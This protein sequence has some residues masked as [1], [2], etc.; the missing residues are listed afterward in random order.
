M[1]TDLATDSGEERN[2]VASWSY[3]QRSTHVSGTRRHERLDDWSTRLQARSSCLRAGAVCD[4][5]SDEDQPRLHEPNAS[6]KEPPNGR[7]QLRRGAPS[8]ACRGWAA[9]LSASHEEKSEIHCRCA[10]VSGTSSPRDRRI[11]LIAVSGF[12]PPEMRAAAATIADRPMPWRQWTAT[13]LPACSATTIWS[14]S[15][16]TASREFGTLRS[17]IGKERNSSPLAAEEA[18]SPARASSASSSGSKSDTT[19]SMPASRQARVSSSSHSAPRGRGT[20]PSR[21]CH[22]PAIQKTFAPISTIRPPLGA[23]RL[24]EGRPR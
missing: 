14:T 2:N 10:C 18:D 15:C 6:L 11:V 3:R 8:A 21:P 9:R 1:N 16:A 23:P 19:M 12:W 22:G 20:I 5:M 4:R 17:G 7:D 13:L 24:V